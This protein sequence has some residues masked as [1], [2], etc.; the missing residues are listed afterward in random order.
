[1]KA[2]TNKPKVKVTHKCDR[3]DCS[4]Q[5]SSESGYCCQECEEKGV[6][7][8]L[9]GIGEALTFRIMAWIP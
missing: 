6:N 8:Y 7:P 5:T 2:R 3:A 4:N 1:M 9:D